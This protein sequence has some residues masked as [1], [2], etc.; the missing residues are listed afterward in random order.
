MRSLASGSVKSKFAHR[1]EGGFI[2]PLLAKLG[3]ILLPLLGDVLKKPA[4][5]LGEFIGRKVK[6]LTGGQ[7]LTQK[8][9]GQLV[10]MLQQG[11]GTKLSGGGMTYH[12][13]LVGMESTGAGS[14]LAGGAL[15]PVGAE[16]PRRK[17]LKK[18]Y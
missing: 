8:E 11:Q 7:A 1:Q 17:T 4:S 12:S 18:K 13:P 9:I 15:R 14:K 6:K 3:P 10:K 5:E 16:A 2:G